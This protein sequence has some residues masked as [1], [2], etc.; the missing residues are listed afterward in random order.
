M[1]LN[2]WLQP[3]GIFTR[4]SYVAYYEFP[5]T[6]SAPCRF[7]TD[8]AL[9]DP[10]LVDAPEFQRCRAGAGSSLFWENFVSL[11]AFGIKQNSVFPHIPHLWERRIMYEVESRISEQLAACRRNH[12]RSSWSDVNIHLQYEA[13]RVKH[14]VDTSEPRVVRASAISGWTMHYGTQ[15]ARGIRTAG[16]SP[17]RPTLWLFNILT[18]SR[19]VTYYEELD[20]QM[21]SSS[22]PMFVTIDDHLKGVSETVLAFHRERLGAFYERHWP[23][24]IGA[25][26]E[27]EGA[28]P[29]PATDAAQFVVTPPPLPTPTPTKTSYLV[30]I[31]R[32]PRWAAVGISRDHSSA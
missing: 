21:S 23:S 18:N 22:R 24:S 25:P 31:K 13:W 4:P 30:G 5:S 8:A 29:R 10:A 11:W 19:T 6:I 32:R 1:T 3:G 2:V 17:Q 27:I 16:R 14:Q 28:V 9:R 20:S 7:A 26:W 12:L 15:I